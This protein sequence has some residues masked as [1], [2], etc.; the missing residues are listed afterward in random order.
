MLRF[1]SSVRI[2]IFDERLQP[3][4]FWASIWS[5]KNREDVYITSVDDGKSHGARGLRFTFHGLNRSL[6]IDLGVSGNDRD[7]IRSLY[8]WQRV[9]LG[10]SYD[11]FDKVNH[12]HHE[13][14][15]GNK[16]I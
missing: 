3:I 15:E 4:L 9:K 13:F 2:E 14:D 16:P 5:L 8:E 11:I 10:G 6:A 7:K 1:N 12:V